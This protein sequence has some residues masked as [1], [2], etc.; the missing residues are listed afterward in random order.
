VRELAN[1][2]NVNFN[3]VA[4]AYRLLDDAGLISTQQGRGTYVLPETHPGSSERLRRLDDLTKQYLEEAFNM[5]ASDGE[6]LA[7]FLRNLRNWS[8]TEESEEENPDTDVSRAG[9]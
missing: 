6:I 1:E 5:D 9:G 4:R 2:L 3:T 7:V 8:E